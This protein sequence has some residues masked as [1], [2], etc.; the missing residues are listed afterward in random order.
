MTPAQT[1]INIEEK[2]ENEI[3]NQN[4]FGTYLAVE[5]NSKN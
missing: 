5:F 2:E 3:Q 4:I 1:N